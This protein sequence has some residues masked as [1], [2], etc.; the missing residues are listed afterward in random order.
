MSRSTN[1]KHTVFIMFFSFISL[2]AAGCS[3]M[4][5]TTLPGQL[6]LDDNFQYREVGQ[7][8]VELTE[9]YWLFGFVKASDERAARAIVE[10]VRRMGGNGVRNLHYKVESNFT[11][12][13]VSCVASPI[14]Y[15]RQ[16]LTI[17]GTV[18]QITGAAS[19][20]NTS[21]RELQAIASGQTDRPLRIQAAH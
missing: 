10:E 6:Y 7:F 13:C 17:S 14:T 5:Y 21:L 3:T 9:S 1:I 12:V 16:T 15:S 2:A 18:V 8:E 11:D 4:S 20:G 19:A